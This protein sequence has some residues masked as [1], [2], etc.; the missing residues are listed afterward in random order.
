MYRNVVRSEFLN[1]LATRNR[2]IDRN[3]VCNDLGPV[4]FSCLDTF[5]NRGVT[6]ST[7]DVNDIRAGLGRAL[8]FSAACIHDLHVSNEGHV[9]E[10]TPELS[11]GFESLAFDQGSADFQPIRTTGNSCLGT[12]DSALQINKIEG[13]L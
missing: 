3:Q 5:T 13:K 6:G 9:G 2:V 11:N 8:D 4:V 10:Q 1:L 7:E 12:L